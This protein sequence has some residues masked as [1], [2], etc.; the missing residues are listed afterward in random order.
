VPASNVIEFLNSYATYSKSYRV[1]SDLIARFVGVM[2][3]GGELTDWTV[4]LIGKS[5]AGPSNE[6]G[7]HAVTMLERTQNK[8]DAT[9]YSIGTLI[10]PR[11]QAIDLTKAQW[12]AALDLT[13]KAWRGDR[14]SDNGKE[15]PKA[16]GGPA[17]R[18]I[19]GDGDSGLD[20]AHERTRGLLLLYLLDPKK[21]ENAALDPTQPVLA[22]AMSLPGSP[23][24]R[25]LTDQDYMANTVEWEGFSDGLG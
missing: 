8:V 14:E 16:P 18:R 3:A 25:G 20:L 5:G 11:D 4:A 19:L 2:A 7:G 21:A 13:Q 22:W 12:G 24:G 17:I 9:S 15:V 6:I 1:R 10:S 23:S